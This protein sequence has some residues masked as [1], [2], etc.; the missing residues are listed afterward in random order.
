MGVDHAFIIGT[1][2]RTPY[3]PI[4]IIRNLKRQKPFKTVA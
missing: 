3:M 1:T 2:S 4:L